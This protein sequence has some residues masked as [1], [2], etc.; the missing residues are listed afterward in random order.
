MGDLCPT[1]TILSL[2]RP[3]SSVINFYTCHKNYI[4]SQHDSNG[5]I[6]LIFLIVI[7]YK[8]WTWCNFTHHFVKL[9][10]FKVEYSFITFT[11]CNVSY[12]KQEC[13]QSQGK[14]RIVTLNGRQRLINF[15]IIQLVSREEQRDVRT[16]FFRMTSGH[17]FSFF[18]LPCKRVSVLWP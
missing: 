15:P 6:V 14:Y 13:L 9:N 5:G 12:K 16:K 2:C 1:S 3:I 18:L 7:Q 10:V 11:I 17:S 4:L 8:V